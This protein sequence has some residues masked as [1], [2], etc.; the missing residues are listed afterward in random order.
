[1]FILY[2]GRFFV[3]RAKKL[4]DKFILNQYFNKIGAVSWVFVPKNPANLLIL[5]IWIQAAV[6]FSRLL[7]LNGGYEEIQL[8][9]RKEKKKRRCGILL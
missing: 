7:V 1:M 4:N 8:L 3:L 6:G 2:V 5:K 9:F